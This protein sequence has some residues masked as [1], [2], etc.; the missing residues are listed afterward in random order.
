MSPEQ[1]SGKSAQMGPRSDVYSLGAILYELL[2]ARPLFEG[3]NVLQLLSQVCTER[4]KAPSDVHP[5]I[6]HDLE[7][8][9]LRCLEKDPALRYPSAGDL[10]R[11]LDRFWQGSLPSMRTIAEQPIGTPSSG[12]SKSKRTRRFWAT[13][14]TIVALVVVAAAISAWIGRSQAKIASPDAPPPAQSAA[15]MTKRVTPRDH[16]DA[17]SGTIN[18]RVWDPKNANRHGLALSEPG[19]LP[20]RQGDQIRVEA[21]LNRSAYL[22]LVWI[23]TDGAAHPVYP[24]KPGDWTAR[25]S[26]ERP[27]VTL[28]LP[29]RIDG[30]WEIEGPAGMET[31]VL[32]A[33]EEPLPLGIKIIDLFAGLPFQTLQSDQALVRLDHGEVVNDRETTRS[34]IFSEVKPL[35]DPVLRTQRMLTERLTPHF[36]VIQSVSFANQGK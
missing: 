36:A 25:I 20:L 14:A 31:L 15:A 22:Y 11:A 12:P 34:P 6:P 9:C 35:S 30:G 4:P 29:E 18:V 21:A 19:A 7:T 3:E 27:T 26:P 28:S 24:W 1:A 2:T 23:G 10:A 32:L 5:G 13:G 16:A 8:I 33:R 17:L